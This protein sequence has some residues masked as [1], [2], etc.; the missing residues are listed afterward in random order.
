M[1]HIAHFYGL[2]LPEFE[3]EDVTFAR[4]R[5]LARVCNIALDQ[6]STSL[7]R[8]VDVYEPSPARNLL[9]LLSTVNEEHLQLAE[10]GHENGSFAMLDDYQWG[11]TRIPPEDHTALR[12]FFHLH[13]PEGY[14]L[15]AQVS[16]IPHE[17]RSPSFDQQTAI[18]QATNAY[19]GGKKPGDWKLDNVNVWQFVPRSTDGMPVY[20]DIDPYAVLV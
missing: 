10:L 16:L 1:T 17:R 2:Q 6:G 12:R 8:Y 11:L 15:V 9:H 7:V 19:G 3:F 18:I 5:E 13:V 20:V 14:T 4:G